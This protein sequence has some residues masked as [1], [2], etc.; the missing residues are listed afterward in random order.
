MIE[1]VTERRLEFPIRPGDLR[2]M[3]REAA[4][5]MEKYRV[6][7]RTSFLSFDG[8]WLVCTFVGP[9]A[10][11]IRSVFRTLGETPDDLWPSTVHH[12][13][14]AAPALGHDTVIVVDRAFDTPVTFEEI[15]A[16]EDRGAWCLSQHHVRFLRTYFA[17][18]RKRMTCVYTAPD[19]EAVQ[20]AQE[21][22]G[23]PLE[24]VWPAWAYE[25]A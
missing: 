5:C 1:I 13:P 24:R 6:R 20:R 21:Q 3:E 14:S 15:Q 25:T 17:T 18:D 12:P 4:W 7:H 2:E 23:M 19:A 9:D 22:A 10:E 11:A 16:L 8:T